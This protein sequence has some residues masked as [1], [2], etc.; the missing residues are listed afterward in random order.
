MILCVE[1]AQHFNSNQYTRNAAQ[2]EQPQDPVIHLPAPKIK[3]KYCKFDYCGK[4]ERRTNGDGWFEVKEQDQHWRSNAARA[5]SRQANRKRNEKAQYE[6]RSR[7]RFPRP[8]WATGLSYQPPI[9][10]SKMV[11]HTGIQTYGYRS[12]RAADLYTP[13]VR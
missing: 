5:H 10:P 1:L 11:R 3:W 6:F 2:A 8:V 13:P 12:N 9:L 7:L 4:D